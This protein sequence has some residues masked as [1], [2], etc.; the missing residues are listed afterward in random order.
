V[1][2]EAS[3]AAGNTSQL[4]LVLKGTGKTVAKR[5]TPASSVSDTIHWNKGGTVADSLFSFT[6][7]PGDLY[8]DC[9]LQA[10]AAFADSTSLG[11]VVDLHSEVVPLHRAGELSLATRAIPD[12]LR[13]H[14]YLARW[15]ARRKHFEYYAKA[16]LVGERAVA[17][18]RDFGRYTLLADTTPPRLE[19]S[20]VA[21]VCSGLPRKNARMLLRARDKVTSIAAVEG[22]ID[23]QWALWEFEPKTG[24]I[25]HDLD[26]TRTA[27]GQ[28]HQL[29]LKVFDAL[30]N[31]QVLECEF[32]W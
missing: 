2:I 29:K 21:K 23:G 4:T 27:K 14:L 5:R 6:L 26:S 30:G 31:A 7:Q 24:E 16:D 19:P 18:V 9:L 28:S 17:K 32:R 12:T 1:T 13:Q 10:K 11:P 3:D 25:W 8:Y 20:R 15:N 22:A